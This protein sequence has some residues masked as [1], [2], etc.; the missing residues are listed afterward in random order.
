[1][2]IV[3]ND[4]IL[5]GCVLSIAILAIISNLFVLL[6][7]TF[8]QSRKSAHSITIVGVAIL[9][10]VMAAAMLSIVVSHIAYGESFVAIRSEW[11][12]RTTCKVCGYLA[13]SLLL[14][15]YIIQLIISVDR[16]QVVKDPFSAITSKSKSKLRV[17]LISTM[18][19]I[20]LLFHC[21]VFINGNSLL[22]NDEMPSD[23]CLMNVHQRLVSVRLLV[24]MILGDLVVPMIFAISIV[25]VCA[26]MIFNLLQ[27]NYNGNLFSAT[28]TKKCIF[29]LICIIILITIVGILM[30]GGLGT[31]IVLRF[32]NGIYIDSMKYIAMFRIVIQNLLNPYIYT[33]TTSLVCDKVMC[34]N[35]AV[36]TDITN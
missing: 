35:K 26:K 20:P 17:C 5:P 18:I 29:R 19:A 36:D 34:K 11:M 9:D 16:Y 8:T 10:L 1:M 12:R 23:I 22:I 6:V 28:N 24:Y 21:E 32:T 25:S 14:P 31:L 30:T 33:L 4:D 27:N 2:C 13:S 3:A 15:N 7:R